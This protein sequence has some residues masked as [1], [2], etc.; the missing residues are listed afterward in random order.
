MIDKQTQTQPY[1]HNIHTYIHTGAT[2]NEELE[3]R[4]I[5]MEE[6]KFLGGDMERTHLV[7]GLDYVLLQKV[8]NEQN[9]KIEQDKLLKES[10]IEVSG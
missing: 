7:R 3:T 8:K 6:S 1:M 9:R 2:T 5:D 4:E 10:A